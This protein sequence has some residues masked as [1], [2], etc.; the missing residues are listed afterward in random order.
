MK[1]P[2]ADAVDVRLAESLHRIESQIDYRPVKVASWGVAAASVL[3]AVAA[4]FGAVAA[5]AGA[6]AAVKTA[7]RVS[8]EGR[9]PRPEISSALSQTEDDSSVPSVHE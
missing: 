2:I 7:I 6:Y 8:H 4:G 9:E 5:I 1:H 3:G